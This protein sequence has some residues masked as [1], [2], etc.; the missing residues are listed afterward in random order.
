MS[1]SRSKTNLV[2]CLLS[3]TALIIG[4]QSVRANCMDTDTTYWTGAN[5][6]PQYDTLVS[7]L[8]CQAGATAKEEAT[9]IDTSACNWFLSKALS[10]LYN[11]SDF[12][13]D[14]AHNWLSAN[15]IY[16]YVSAGGNWSKLGDATDQEVLADAAQG[17]ANGQPVIAV[18]KGNPHGHV[19][20]VLPGPLT[21]SGNWG[22]KVPNSASFF[23]DE[24]KTVKKAYVGCKLSYAFADPDGVEIYWRLKAQ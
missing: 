21:Q 1:Q 3:A 2:R 11:V 7:L 5:R 12:A 10:V 19:A 24:N 23:L 14:T 6:L 8:A 16:D 22:L 15:D 13:P 17:A 4:S 18:I 20:L 9:L